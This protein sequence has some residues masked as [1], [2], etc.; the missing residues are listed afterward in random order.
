VAKKEPKVA[1]LE[2]K[3]VKAYKAV[4]AARVAKVKAK[5]ALDKAIDALAAARDEFE[6][7]TDDI[8]FND[9]D[10]SFYADDQSDDD[11]GL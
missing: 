7:V 6:S 4:E 5:E 8:K 10:D 3:L 1:P 2:A 11:W 9:M